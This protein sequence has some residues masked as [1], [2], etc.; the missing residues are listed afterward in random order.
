MFADC[1]VG[2][3]P[4]RRVLLEPGAVGDE[5]VGHAAFLHSRQPLG[6]ELR[7][8]GGD[9]SLVVQVVL[10]R[11]L[12]VGPRVVSDAGRCGIARFAN[13]REILATLLG[14][15]ESAVPPT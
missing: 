2:L 14:T 13:C 5:D 3:L 11:R 7:I 12:C 9:D 10:Y 4:F 15:R 8:D 1:S 6:R